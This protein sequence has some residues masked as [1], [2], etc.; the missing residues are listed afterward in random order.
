L[1][2][3]L[4]FSTFILS[5]SFTFSISLS[6]LSS[7]FFSDSSELLEEINIDNIKENEIIID[8]EINEIE[9]ENIKSD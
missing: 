2:S 5:I 7:I 8:N 1:I 6:I 9:L 3:D 4:I